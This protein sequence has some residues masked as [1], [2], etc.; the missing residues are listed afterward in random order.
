MEIM[1]IVHGQSEYRICSSIKSNLRL[2]HEI[3][4][5]DKGKTSIQVTSVMNI[6]NDRRFATFKG[7]IRQFTDVNYE[8]GKLLNFSLFIIMDVDDCTPEQKNEFITKEMFKNHWLYEYIV[9]IYND[10]NLEAAM[11]EAHIEV[12]R[13]KDYIIIFPTNHGDLDVTIA[14]EY[15]D[16]T[17]RCKCS[18]LYRYIEH[19][20]FLAEKRT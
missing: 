20:I 11:K 13:K 8:K 2:K 3:I 6:L 7:F 18:N 4:A 17:K 14:K 19:C 12:K 15:L 1:S 5:R 16:K 10:P 9:P